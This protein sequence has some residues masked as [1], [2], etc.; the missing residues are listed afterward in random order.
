MIKITVQTIYNGMVGV[1]D[2]YIRQVRDEQK[3]LLIKHKGQTMTMP[4]GTVKD[5][6][7]YRSQKQFKDKFSK[8]THHLYYFRWKPDGADEEFIRQVEKDLAWFETL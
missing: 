8:D 2:K 5:R 3:G 7:V 6:I 1:R 4:Y